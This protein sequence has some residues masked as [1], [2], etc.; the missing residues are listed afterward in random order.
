MFERKEKQ[1]TYNSKATETRKSVVLFDINTVIARRAATPAPHCANTFTLHTFGA[2]GVARRTE[3]G[4]SGRIDRNP[5][6]RWRAESKVNGLA[7]GSM[8]VGLELYIE[9]ALNELGKLWHCYEIREVREF[10]G[11]TTC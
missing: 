11:I 6:R 1:Y 2:T 8:G 5:S 7:V 4:D 9:E 3:N 10:A